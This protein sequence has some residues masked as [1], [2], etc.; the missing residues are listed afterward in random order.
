[1]VLG[2][3]R[4]QLPIINICKEHGCE[5]L[6]VSPKGNYPG[7]DYADGCHLHNV[8]D[9]EAV[10]DVARRE[11][12]DAVLTDQLD[13]GVLTAAYIAERLGLPGIGY[14]TA[15]RFTN[16]YIM[17]KSAEMLGFNVPKFFSV[18]TID[19]V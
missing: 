4:G 16:K 18:S 2:A 10:L 15:L 1:M 8:K 12:I 6:V 14:E 3:G 7:F 13:A 5:V 9:K 17:R 11:R 19:Q